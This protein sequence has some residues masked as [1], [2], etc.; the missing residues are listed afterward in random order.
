[1]VTYNESRHTVISMT[2]CDTDITETLL[3][4]N[5]GTKG[6]LKGDKIE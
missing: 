3:K 2:K 4:V 5:K 1:M 6:S